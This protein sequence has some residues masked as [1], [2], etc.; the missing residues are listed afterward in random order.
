MSGH[1]PLGTA[2]HAPWRGTRRHHIGTGRRI[3]SLLACVLALAVPPVARASGWETIERADGILVER[4]LVD[5][6]TLPEIRVTAHTWV[7]PAA[8]FD[9][10]W[11]QREYLEFVPYLKRLEVIAETADER[12]IYEQVTLPFVRDRDYTVRVRRRMDPAR[13]RYEAVF[14]S[15]DH[16]GPAPNNAYIRARSIAGSWTVEPDA[17]GRGSVLRYVVRSDPGGMIP[18]WAMRL[19]QGS[20]A[21]DLVRAMI[22]RAGKMH[23]PELRAPSAR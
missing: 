21:A 4:R 1:I 12:I 14:A 23:G 22:E 8:L 5:G 3:V 2:G 7:P 19:G 13:Q 11:R 15:V 16:M 17:A 10:I 6:A 18:A 20:A 9:T